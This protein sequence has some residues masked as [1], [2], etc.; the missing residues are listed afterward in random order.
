M[1]DATGA[2]YFAQ[3]WSPLRKKKSVEKEAENRDKVELL[4]LSPR[5]YTLPTVMYV[6]SMGP[7]Y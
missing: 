4:T 5:L 3:L 2:A 6:E 7:P 1:S